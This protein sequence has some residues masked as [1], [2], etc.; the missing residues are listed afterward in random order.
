MCAE[1]KKREK[2]KERVKYDNRSFLCGRKKI[3]EKGG[4]RMRS[5]SGRGRKDN[6][7]KKPGFFHLSERMDSQTEQMKREEREGGREGGRDREKSR[8]KMKF[9]QKF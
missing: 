9:T 4:R 2:E 7:L 3:P 1:K 6:T 8:R 5:G